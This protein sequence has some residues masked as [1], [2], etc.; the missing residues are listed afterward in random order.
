M[1]YHL[2]VEHETSPVDCGETGPLVG[3]HKL[4]VRVEHGGGAGDL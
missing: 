1:L 3:R 4:P 2:Y